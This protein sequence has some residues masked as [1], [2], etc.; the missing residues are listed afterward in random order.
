VGRKIAVSHGQRNS[1]RLAPRSLDGL[2]K[3]RGHPPQRGEARQCADRLSGFTR[4]DQTADAPAILPGFLEVVECF[5]SEG[6]DAAHPSID[7]GDRL[8]AGKG[9]NV[10]ALRAREALKDEGGIRVPSDERP[11]AQ[12]RVPGWRERDLRAGRRVVQVDP[13]LCDHVIGCSL[14]DVLPGGVEGKPVREPLAVHIATAPLE[15]AAGR[16]VI[17]EKDS[18][19]PCEDQVGCLDLALRR[20][21]GDYK[22]A[23]GAEGRPLGMQSWPNGVAV[24]RRGDLLPSVRRVLAKAADLSPSGDVP[25]RK[26]GQDKLFDKE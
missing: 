9:G 12:C 10:E 16:T 1:L 6:V 15:D 25:Q 17:Q 3:G 13:R 4:E 23:V 26:W 8:E 18:G 21:A 7:P 19:G 24:L 22:P 2:Q 20:R 11:E 5:R 14:E